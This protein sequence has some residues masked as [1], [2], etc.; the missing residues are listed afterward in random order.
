MERNKDTL[1]LWLRIVDISMNGT[2]EPENE[3]STKLVI[4]SIVFVK[5]IPKA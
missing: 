3:A 1:N 5:R 4:N 2:G